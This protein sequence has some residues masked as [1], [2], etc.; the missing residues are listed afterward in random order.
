MLARKYGSSG[1]LVIVLHGG[2]AAAGEAA[3]IARGLASSFRALEPFQRGSGEEPL[4]VARHIAD[5]DLLITSNAGGEKTAIAG[6]SWGAMLALAYAA[7]HPAQAGPLALIGCGTFD[8]KARA[9]LEENLAARMDSALRARL[10]RL[11]HEI[12]DPEERQ[13]RRYELTKELYDFDACEPETDLEA[14]SFDLRAHR[15]TWED[16]LRLQDRGVYPSAF[17]AI[18]SPVIMIHGAYDPHP[19]RLIRDGLR[20]FIPQLEYVELERC[21]H[22]PWRERAARERFFAELRGWLLRHTA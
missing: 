18:R 4:T 6:E 21:G 15:E 9:Q 8:R 10:A 1:P 14:S 19:G 22:S 20:E 2:P 5:L 7:A 16:M 12:S 11:E 13:L 17:V 3:P